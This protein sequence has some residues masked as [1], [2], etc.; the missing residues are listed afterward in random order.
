MLALPVF[1]STPNPSPEFQAYIY[2]DEFTW[3]ASQASH[4]QNQSHV[5]SLKPA[6]ATQ[7]HPCPSL[8]ISAN[9][10]CL[11]NFPLNPLPL[12]AQI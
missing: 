6:S 10:N 9:V 12:T 7:S 11:Q 8:L 1:M 2:K 5:L 4:I 3:T